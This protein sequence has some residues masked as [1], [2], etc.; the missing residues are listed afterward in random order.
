MNKKALAVAI[1]TAVSVPI[2][3][4]AVSVK[5][6]GHV[7]RAIRYVSD[8]T[9]SQLQNIDGA[10][11]GTRFGL[12]GSE[13]M[14]GG[15]SLG[16]NIELGVGSDGSTDPTSKGADKDHSIFAQTELHLVWGQLGHTLP[17][18]YQRCV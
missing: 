18:E 15:N 2:V 5:T 9:D 11:S 7:N 14:G 13:K 17:W 1:A 4:E 12:K 16:L 3:A 6:Y 8:G 10:G